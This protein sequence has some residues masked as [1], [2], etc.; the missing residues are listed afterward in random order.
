MHH[1]FHFVRSLSFIENLYFLE[2][3]V[4]L[5]RNHLHWLELW[6]IISIT[7]VFG[8]GAAWLFPVHLFPSAVW[9]LAMSHPFVC[10][11]TDFWSH[12]LFTWFDCWAQ[13]ESEHRQRTDRETG[14]EGDAERCELG[15]EGWWVEGGKV[16]AAAAR[17][18]LRG[19]QSMPAG[20]PSKNCLI[21]DQSEIEFT[22]MSTRPNYEM[23]AMAEFRG[24]KSNK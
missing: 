20:R 1:F 21:W 10:A 7:V 2:L 8:T 16:I 4:A 18:E 6:C 13:R 24:F 3:T 12:A 5:I 19:T 17:Y 22:S 14:M 11:A 15:S 23:E 9:G